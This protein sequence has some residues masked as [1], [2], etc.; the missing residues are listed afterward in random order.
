MSSYSFD[1]RVFYRVTANV[2]AL[3]SGVDLAAVPFSKDN[4]MPCYSSSCIVAR[5]PHLQQCT[6]GG[7]A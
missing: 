6:V 1:F 3:L 7:W 5:Q 4:Q 2:K